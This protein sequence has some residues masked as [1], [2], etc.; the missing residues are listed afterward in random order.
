[1]RVLDD[2][3][4]Q[5]SYADP[6]TLSYV[7]RS[8]GGYF[9]V[10][11]ND[12]FCELAYGR[13]GEETWTSEV[14]VPVGN[15]ILAA[16]TIGVRFRNYVAGQTARVSAALSSHSEPPLQIAAGG[17]NSTPLS[18]SVLSTPISVSASGST[19]IVAGVA[20]QVVSVVSVGLM[21]AGSVSVKFQ[22]TGGPT[23]LTGAY[24]L[25]ASTGFVLGPG[26]WFKTGTGE[27]LAL[28]LSAAVAVGG[29]V[30]FQYRNA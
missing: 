4:C 18:S 27:G 14:H 5:D 19:T 26:S 13:Q 15:G 3:S 10:A 2:A 8:N 16:N 22:T 7:Y 9:A 24:P 28:N 1:V 25:V 21:A 6:A 12:V 20:G 11:D 29:V 30:T 23:D 17:N